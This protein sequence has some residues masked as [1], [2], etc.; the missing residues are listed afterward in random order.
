MEG[1][2]RVG[3]ESNKKEENHLCCFCKMMIICTNNKMKFYPVSKWFIFVVY[4]EKLTFWQPLRCLFISVLHSLVF[5]YILICS[6][7]L[8]C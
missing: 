6:V 2:V 8:L 1:I 3:S 7:Y 5:N 4:S